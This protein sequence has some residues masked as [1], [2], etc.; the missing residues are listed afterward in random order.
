MTLPCEMH[1][2]LAQSAHVPGV[3]AVN[4]FIWKP[5]QELSSGRGPGAAHVG[6]RMDSKRPHKHLN[7]RAE[8]TLGGLPW[9]QTWLGAPDP[10][11]GGAQVT[12]R[13]LHAPPASQ[14]ASTLHVLFLCSTT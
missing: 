14:G 8:E 7:K 1:L 3:G 9:N 5:L 4:G 12:W 2:S 6:G 11:R 10:L 13:W